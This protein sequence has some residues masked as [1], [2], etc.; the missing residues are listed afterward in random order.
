LFSSCGHFYAGR[1]LKTEGRHIHI[2]RAYTTSVSDD[3]ALTARATKSFERSLIFNIRCYV[4]D[5]DNKV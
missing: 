4:Q 3:D 2:M 5:I 1:R